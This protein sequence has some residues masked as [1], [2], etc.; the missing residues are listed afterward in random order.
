VRLDEARGRQ[1]D[2]LR[3]RELWIEGPVKVGERLHGDDAG[4]FEATGKEAIGAT[5]ELV[6]DEQLE[7]LEVRERGGFGLGDARGQGL[8]HAG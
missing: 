1:L 6:L 8:D 2:E 3:F 4:L 5:G 7:K